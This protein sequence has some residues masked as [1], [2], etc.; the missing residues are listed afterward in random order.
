MHPVLFTIPRFSLFGIHFGEFEVRSYGV[1]LMIGILFAMWWSARRARRWGIHP[2]R[3]MDAA[4]WGIVPGII[5]ARLGFIIQEWG[6]YS[7]HTNELWSLRFDGL[8]SFGGILMAVVGLWL[9]TKRAKISTGAFFDVLSAPLL[10]AHAIGRVGCLLNGCCYGHATTAWFGVHVE[11]VEGLYAPAQLYDSFYVL[12]GLC[13][14]WWFEHKPRPAGQSFALAV[15]LWGAAR[16]I[17]EFA[18]AGSDLQ[19]ASGQATSTYWGTLPVTQAQVAA[20]VL[21]VLGGLWLWVLGRRSRASL[22]EDAP[23]ETPE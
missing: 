17:Y 23:E 18:R 19:V 15:L 20:L 11:G 21:V 7:K 1:M 9:Y 4:F 13:V 6:Y 22:P 10:V 12:A 5:G 14:L 16:F 8:T 3:V 2:E